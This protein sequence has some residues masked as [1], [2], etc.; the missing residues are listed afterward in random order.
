MSLTSESSHK[1]TC[2]H[3]HNWSSNATAAASPARTTACFPSR[4]SSDLVIAVALAAWWAK[5]YVPANRKRRRPGA[6]HGFVEVY[7]V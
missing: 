2:E 1:P 7:S 3:D 4:R 5:N 6:E